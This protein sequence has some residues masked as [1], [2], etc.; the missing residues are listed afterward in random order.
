MGEMLKELGKFLYNLSLLIAGALIFQPLAKGKLSS[1]L[2]VLSITSIL[3]F[4][5]IG[6]VFIYFGEKFKSKED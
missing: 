3:S 4:V 5:F 2:L 6:S 1:H